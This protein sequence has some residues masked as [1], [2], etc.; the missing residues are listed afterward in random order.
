MNEIHRYC[1]KIYIPIVIV[2]RVGPTVGLT[3]SVDGRKKKTVITKINWY[4]SL[5]VCSY[6]L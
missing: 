1:P 6:D 4:Y 5:L 2:G 3:M